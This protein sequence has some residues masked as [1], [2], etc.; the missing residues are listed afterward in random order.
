LTFLVCCAI[1]L[2]ERS[3]HREALID[4]DKE[5]VDEM[6]LALMYLVMRGDKDTARAWKGFEWAAMDRLHEKGMCGV[7]PEKMKCRPS[8]TLGSGLEHPRNISGPGL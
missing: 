7:R 8:N 4:Y 3:G 6:T 2:P 1:V 5:K